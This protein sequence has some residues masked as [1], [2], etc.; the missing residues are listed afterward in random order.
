MKKTI[1]L[2]NEKETVLFLHYEGA[3][4]TFVWHY[5]KADKEHCLETHSSGTV[6]R[7]F[8]NVIYYTFKNKRGFHVEELK[9]EDC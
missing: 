4:E 7:E 5:T 3:E 9:V 2:S 8:A 6:P 1:V